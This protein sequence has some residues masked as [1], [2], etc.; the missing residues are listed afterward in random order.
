MDKS[1]SV[2]LVI[3]ARCGNAE[4]R[5]LAHY[6]IKI[7]QPVG[8]GVIPRYYKQPAYVCQQCFDGFIKIED[9]LEKLRYE[10]M[11]YWFLHPET[12][13]TSLVRKILQ[14]QVTIHK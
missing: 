2:D 11:H 3:C 9:A 6:N 1:R 13:A 8:E 10:A 12:K 7:G 14:M 4:V 5:S